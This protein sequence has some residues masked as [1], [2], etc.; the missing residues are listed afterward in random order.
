ML[1][2]VQETP[3]VQN[4]SLTQLVILMV[5]PV[6]HVNWP[7][8]HP[9][10][11]RIDFWIDRSLFQQFRRK[12]A[13]ISRDTMNPRTHLERA[14]TRLVEQCSKEAILCLVDLIEKEQVTNKMT[15]YEWSSQ[16][17]NLDVPSSLLSDVIV[18]WSNCD[19]PPSLL[20]FGLAVS[21]ET[22][23]Q[24][25][26][27]APTMDL[28]WTGPYPPSA[29]NVRSTLAVMQ[30]MIASSKKRIL[31]VG[32]SL[33]LTSEAPKIVLDQLI[34]A[35]KRGCD[36]RIALH[37]NGFNYKNMMSAWPKDITLPTL[38]KWDGKPGDDMSSLHA[39]LLLVDHSELLVTSA[40]FTHHG[41]FTNI[42]VGVRVKGEIA[43][44][45]S[46]HFFSLE[47]SGILR[48]IEGDYQ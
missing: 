14:I 44:Q 5:Q 28:V 11:S 34:A 10:K 12:D 17:I 41:L 20:A 48:R 22:K 29:G 18:A 3:Y 40:N 43:Q 9:V 32:Y 16:L 27:K 33:T 37:D 31:L 21:S 45:M 36:I 47:R 13:P 30:E 35:K 26:K 19:L 46:N 24:L 25:L 6:T 23:L 7:R 2:F 15:T 42:E 38:L 39:K 8:R 4:I 1:G